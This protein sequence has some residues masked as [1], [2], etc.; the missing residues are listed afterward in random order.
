M[1]ISWSLG[2]KAGFD[3]R[4]AEVKCVDIKSIQASAAL[5]LIAQHTMYS[6]RGEASLGCSVA[7]ETERTE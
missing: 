6:A 5:I 4:K 1:A 2:N 3:Y 7:L